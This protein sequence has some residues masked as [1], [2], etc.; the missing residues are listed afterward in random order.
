M[1]AQDLWRSTEQTRLEGLEKFDRNAM[2]MAY[3]LYHLDFTQLKQQLD[4]APLRNGG[5]ISNVNIQFPTKKGNFE[6]FVVYNAPV[7]ADEL[8]LKFPGLTSYVGQSIENPANTVRFSVTQFG[9]HA[10]FFREE[11]VSYID[12]YTKDLS[13]YIFYEKAALFQDRNFECLVTD[14]GNTAG[15]VAD[16]GGVN[17][18]YMDDSTLRSYRLAMACT[19]EYAAFHIAEAGVGSGTLAQQKA[20]VLAAMVVTMTRVNGIY[21]RDMAVTMVLVANNE[22]VIY[23]TSDSFTNDNANALINE[24]QTVINSVIGSANYDIGHT[25]STGGGGLA[26]LNVPCTTNKARG[27]TGSPSPVGDTYDI[28]YVAHEMGHQ[29][30]AHHTFNNSCSGNRTD[31]TAVEPGSGSTIMAYA[32]I[33]APNVQN[34]SDDHFHAISIAEMRSCVL[35]IATCSTNTPNGNTVPVVNAGNDYTI[36]KGTPFVLEAVGTDADGDALTYCW[37]QTDNE[38]STQPPVETNNSGPNYRSNSPVASP[39]RYFPS[40]D[41]VLLDNLTPTWEVTPNIGR[42]MNFACTVRDNQLIAGGQTSRDDMMITVNGFMGPFDVT[43]QNT[44]GISWTQGETRTITWDVNN[45]SSLPGATNVDI[46]LSTD[47]GYTYDTMLAANTPNDGS[48]DITVP[49]VAAPFCRVMV[50]PTGNVFYDINPVAF[51]IGYTVTNTCYTYTNNTPLAVPDGAGANQPGT[52]VSNTVTVA[53]NVTIT[54]VN[55][56]VDVSHT[57]IEDLVIAVNHPNG[58]QVLL[59][60]RYCDGE[61]AFNITFDD[62]GPALATSGCT[63]PQTGTFAPYGSLADFNGLT[64]P[65]DWELLAVDYYTGDTGT[66]NSWTLEICEQQ[67]TMKNDNFNSLSEFNVY[68]N[69]NNGNFSVHLMSTS[70]QDINLE[71]FDIRGRNVFANSYTNTGTFNQVINLDN[72]TPGVYMLNVSDGESK[73]TKKIVIQ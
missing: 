61:D 9:L 26:Q 65:G 62:D 32:G 30:G 59:W 10:M 1:Y 31:A 57:Y 55:V 43:S 16:V 68:P 48:E 51:A 12:T 5:A 49:N 33:C 25:V 19:I 64:S 47:G 60:G 41:A 34:N 28:D 63:N 45:T 58:D 17:A 39:M 46:M 54:D 22:D 8:A 38:I 24:S 70:S 14:N 66:V 69:P 52:V 3:G 72:V 53:D 67:A 27:I 71:L 50:K 40:L 11:G 42:T 36:P 21:E 73:E 35:N 4:S 37:E 23:V 29:F 56:T 6:S 13:N 15:K 44:T 7:V 2:P 18:P 20:A